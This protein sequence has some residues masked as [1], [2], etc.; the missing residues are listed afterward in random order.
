[1]RQPP[2]HA[3]RPRAR[4]RW[5]LREWREHRGISQEKLAAMVGWTQG[6]I[7]QL[8]LNKVDY[9]A[10]GLEALAAALECDVR[11]L[12]FRRPTDAEGLADIVEAIP[13]AE[14]GRALEIM[15]TFKRTAG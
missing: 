4:R 6:Q 2:R 7:S 5:F 9:T 1:M 3:S 12:L 11:D 8:E 15:K 10:T 13:E 14:R